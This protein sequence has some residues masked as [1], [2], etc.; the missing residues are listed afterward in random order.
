MTELSGQVMFARFI[1]AI[2]I[3][4]GA[5]IVYRVWKFH[6]DRHRRKKEIRKFI[7]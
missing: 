2:F 3:F 7:E 4:L 1:G 5:Y 6:S